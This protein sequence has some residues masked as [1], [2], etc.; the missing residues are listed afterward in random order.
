MLVLVS[1]L[2]FRLL[3]VRVITGHNVLTGLYIRAV[4][5]DS[6]LLLHWLLILFVNSRWQINYCR[7]EILPPQE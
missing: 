7:Q 1:V 5:F 4:Y 3:L 6:Y 2:D